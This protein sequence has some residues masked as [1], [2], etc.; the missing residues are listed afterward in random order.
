[1]AKD[2]S[3]KADLAT[4]NWH[5]QAREIQAFGTVTADLPHPLD[6]KVRTEMVKKL[7]QLLADSIALRDMYKKHHWQVGGPTFYQLHLLFDKHFEEQVD[8][9]DTIAERIQL[10]G[11]VTVAMGGDVAEMT[12]VPRPPKGKEEVPVQ[13]S[14]LLEAHKIIIKECLD[15]S[16]AADDAGD[17]GTN[18]LVVSD[19]LRP[20]ELQSWFIGQHLVE[21]PLTFAV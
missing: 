15:I 5:A 4:P 8:I 7:N 19:V 14:R 13:I 17:Q 11:G 10:L 3:G 6:Q 21:M 1:M 2:K 9:V 18:D 16:E 20:N 12:K